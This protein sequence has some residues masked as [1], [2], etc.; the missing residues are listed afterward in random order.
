MQPLGSLQKLTE[1]CVYH[2]GIK[3]DAAVLVQL[4]NLQQLQFQELSEAEL[5]RLTVLQQLTALL[6]GL[7]WPGK[8]DVKV[9]DG[10]SSVDFTVSTW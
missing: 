7:T 4:T 6:A 1:L 10:R 2:T 5:L 9:W 8:E 3:H